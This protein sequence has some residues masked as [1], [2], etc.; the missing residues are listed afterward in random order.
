MSQRSFRAVFGAAFVIVGLAGA[1]ACGAGFLDGLTGGDAGSGPATPDTSAPVNIGCVGL[2]PPDASTATE[3]GPSIDPLSFAFETVRI[4]GNPSIDSGAPPPVGFNLDHLCTCG[5]DKTPS[6]VL[7]DAGATPS[8]PICDGDGGTDDGLASF[9]NTLALAIPE[10]KEDFAGERIADGIFTVFLEVNNWNG[11]PEDPQV[12]VRIRMSPGFDRDATGRKKPSFDGT[13]VWEVDPTSIVDGNLNLGK[14]C[15]APTTGGVDICSATIADSHAFVTGGRLIAHPTN[16]SLTTPLVLQSSVGRITVDLTNTI[17][18]AVIAPNG[19]GLWKMTGEINGRWPVGSV[20]NTIA[21]IENPFATGGAKTAICES[22]TGV[23]SAYST[24]KAGVCVG[25]DLAA[26]PSLDSNPLAPCAAVSSSL[27]FV[28][29]T[30]TA[31][32]IVTNPPDSANC[33]DW[34]DDCTH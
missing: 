16:I 29:S 12:L 13:D 26:S 30:A 3:D 27:S 19:P 34:K 33:V 2:V 10:F 32:H 18:D 7:P 6:C 24:L 28:A 31:G 23:P 22:A 25:L 8:A 14:D 11:Q 1:T 15:R 17:L 9:F 5:E 21:N 4:T 20:L